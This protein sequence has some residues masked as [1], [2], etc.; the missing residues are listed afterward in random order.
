M[1]VFVDLEEEDDVDSSPH[2][3]GLVMLNPSALALRP[4]TERMEEPQERAGQA[5]DPNRD[6][7][8]A[9]ALGC[10]P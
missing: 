3:N 10:Y 1:A 7:P 8:M 5:D 2:P 4:K 6:S 9:T